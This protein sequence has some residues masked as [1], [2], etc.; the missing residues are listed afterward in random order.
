MTR[1]SETVNSYCRKISALLNTR[2]RVESLVSS[3]SMGVRDC[4]LSYESIFLNS[5]CSFEGVLQDLLVEFVCGKAS[6]RA[7]HASKIKTRS[8]DVFYGILLQG[9]KYVDVLPYKERMPDLA[10]L[11]LKDGRPFTSLQT[12]Q[13][14]ALTEIAVIRNAIAH[15]KGFALKK[16]RENIL[17]VS[18]L[19]P[20]RRF[21]GP[22]LRYVYKANPNETYLEMYLSS[23]ANIAKFLENEWA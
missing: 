14:A 13:K 22:M 16:F 4:C 3:G 15:Q 21:P 19:P 20:P 6:R 11:Y 17:A 1:A 5:V 12:P 23:L 10:K 9:R 18:Y 7:G 8:R 2:T